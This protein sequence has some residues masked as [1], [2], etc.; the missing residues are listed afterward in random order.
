M[1]TYNIIM[2][3]QFN[4]VNFKKDGNKETITVEVP[5]FDK[6]NK[7]HTATATVT[8]RTLK[9]SASVEGKNYGLQIDDVDLE[10]GTKVERGKEQFKVTVVN[11][12][13]ASLE[14]QYKG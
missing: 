10:T 6:G 4:S 3:R 5:R 8:G 2:E 7:S 1:K 14:E 13:K 9:I 11:N 12:G